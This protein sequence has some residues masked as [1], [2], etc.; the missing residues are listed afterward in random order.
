[1]F[2]AIRNTLE[3][4]GIPAQV[5]IAVIGIIFASDFIKGVL[6]YI[7]DYVEEKKGRQI[8]LFDHTKIL[9]VFFCSI[10]AALTLWGLKIIK[11]VEV[12]IY[13]LALCGVSCILYDVVIRKVKQKIE[14][15]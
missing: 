4:I 7:E 2:E 6:A 13:S 12:V 10:I 15:V 1:M 14:D 5:I 11:G 8:K 9:I 3:T